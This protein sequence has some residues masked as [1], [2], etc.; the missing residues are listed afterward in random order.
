MESVDFAN[1]S[2]DVLGSQ[3]IALT[4]PKSSPSMGE[5]EAAAIASKAAG[6]AAVL[7]SRYVYCRMVSKHPNI[8]QDC[9]AFSLDPSRR[10]APIGGTLATYS[11]VLVDPI[12]GEILLNQIGW[13][14]TNPSLR[15]DPRLGP[16]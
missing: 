8:E 7:E 6:G 10:S 13:P 16:A 4:E 2:T 12:S 9:W 15:R 11:L 14:G 5:A 1:V 3:G